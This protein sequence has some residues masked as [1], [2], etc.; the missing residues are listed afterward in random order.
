MSRMSLAAQF[1]RGAAAGRLDRLFGY[2]LGC[3]VFVTSSQ[4]L[5]GVAL[6]ILVA[7]RR[8]AAAAVKFARQNRIPASDRRL[9]ANTWLL[10]KFGGRP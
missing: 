1:M 6:P 4:V 8:E 5:L 2:K 7:V 3:Y 10:S 9:R